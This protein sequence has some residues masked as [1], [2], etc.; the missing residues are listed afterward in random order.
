M[1]RILVLVLSLSISVA[2]LA[3]SNWGNSA[4]DSIV[5]YE[6]YNTFGSLYNSKAYAEA[7]EPWRTVYETCPKVKEVIYIFAPKI[8]DAKIKEA[9]DPVQ[10]EALIRLLLSTYDQ[11][12]AYFPGKEA[13]VNAQKAD[14]FWTYYPDNAPA[15][16]AMYKE[17]FAL[18]PRALQPAYLNNYFNVV[19]KLY[20]DEKLNSAGL[21]EGFNDV[22]EAIELQSN[23]RNVLIAALVKDTNITEREKRNLEVNRRLLDQSEKLIANI[24]KGIAP[25]LTCERLTLIYNDST[26]AIHTSDKN[27]LV[28]S[29][30]MLSKDRPGVDGTTDC[31]DNPMYIKAASALYKLDPSAQAARSMGLLSIKNGLYADSKKYFDDAIRQEV[32]PKKKAKDWMKLA[33]IAEKQGQL[34]EAKRACLE[35]ARANPESGEPYL[36]LALIYGQAADS[37]GSNAFEKN[38]VYWA[39][40]SMAN[41]AASV[42]PDLSAK[43]ES[44]ASS[45]GKNVPDKS[46]AFQFNYKEG[47]SYTVG[48]WINERIVV[49]F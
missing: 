11:R 31:T 14:N 49:R 13:E 15:A 24:E 26:F 1:K 23:E 34:A 19:I 29:L 39:A 46:I 37:C 30:K 21:V 27:W 20:K 42:Q 22:S 48:C 2:S 25:L 16:Y 32:D 38:A 45:Y 12:N 44:L 9:T 28:R 10:R 41:R 43:A 17:V 8:L 3:Q 40:I 4:T 33:Q 6:K 5:C 47:D 35:S 36:F 7:Y 18:D